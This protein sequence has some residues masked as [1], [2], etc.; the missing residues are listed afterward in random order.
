MPCDT[1]QTMSVNLGKVDRELL[2]QALTQLGITR[3]ELKGETLTVQGRR[4]SDELA[5]QIKVAYSRQVVL[6]QA[7]RFGWTM[8]EVA[9][10]KWEVV[11]R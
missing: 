1:I 10:N 9:A 11:R 3:W 2:A 8:K 4:V 5:K 7:K 6:S